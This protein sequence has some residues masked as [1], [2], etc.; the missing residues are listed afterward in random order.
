MRQWAAVVTTLGWMSVP[1]Q[2]PHPPNE[3]VLGK[4]HALVATPPM[5][6][7]VEARVSAKLPFAKASTATSVPSQPAGPRNLFIGTSA[8]PAGGN[9]APLSRN[10]AGSSA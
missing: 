10:P 4:P 6:V 2:E 8:C 3:T 1:E 5:T 9:V 7:G